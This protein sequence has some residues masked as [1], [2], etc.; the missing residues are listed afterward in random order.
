MKLFEGINPLS[1]EPVLQ[2]D[3]PD[4][5]PMSGERKVSRAFTLPD[6][7]IA[8]F[9]ADFI[10]AYDQQHR[11][12]N[13]GPAHYAGKG[14]IQ[15]AFDNWF[16]NWACKYMP[17]DHVHVKNYLDLIPEAYHNRLT[18]HY[19]A[20]P[21][22]VEFIARSTCEGSMEENALEGKP[23]CGQELPEGIRLGQ[24]LPRP[25]FT[26]TNKAPK[27]QKDRPLTLEEYYDTI[28]SVVL[29][30]YLY[31]MT[32]LLH[33]IN[34]V[35][36]RRKG[37]D[38]PDQKKEFGRLHFPGVSD[39]RATYTSKQ[40]WAQRFTYLCKE[41]GFNPL[42]WKQMPNFN[43]NIFCDYAEDN[44]IDQIY[45]LIDSGG[46]TDDGRYRMLA[47]TRMGEL[48]YAKGC[49]EQ[50]RAFMSNYQC[51]EF[52]R[53]YSKLTGKGGYAKPAGD[54]VVVPDTILHETGR[55][56]LRVLLAITQ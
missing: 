44:R 19:P 17:T 4:L 36:A 11:A 25:F 28:G 13:G 38:R 33:L 29:G 30:N 42:A 18:V 47:D 8:L 6:D 45:A 1:T 21:I 3:I 20:D 32:I 48:L 15:T 24:M 53:T 41:A 31:G 27:G 51:K 26:P 37:V 9:A 40:G 35:L 12:E 54:I 39:C 23:I 2:F 49:P 56:N 22:K 34:R 52:F 7:F 55:R 16:K 50:A 46:G 14:M 10:G 5:K 43:L